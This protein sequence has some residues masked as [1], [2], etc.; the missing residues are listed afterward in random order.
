M[1]IRKINKKELHRRLPELEAIQHQVKYPSVDL[2]KGLHVWIA[3]ENN[4]IVGFGSAKCIHGFWFLRADMVLPSARG[5]GIQDR[6][7]K[8]RL[9]YLKSKKVK[10]VTGWVHPYNSYSFNN[11]IRNGFLL[12]PCK[13]R[14]F[15]NK[16]HLVTY[17]YL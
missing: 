15:D 6:L 12:K 5:K 2:K 9:R 7:I 1:K 3:E 17:K 10:G 14:I 16:E 13:P 4:K 11:L 8:A